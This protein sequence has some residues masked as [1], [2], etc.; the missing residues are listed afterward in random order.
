MVD[1]KGIQNA[2]VLGL[3][4]SGEAAARLLRAKGVAV[5]IFDAAEEASLREDVR[6]DLESLGC[7]VFPGARAVAG[8][9]FDVAVISPGVSDSSPLFTSVV[10]QGI[11]KISEL[12]LGWTYLDV[13]VI[14][15]TGSNGKSTLVKLCAD[16]LR[17]VP[18]QCEAGGNFGTPLCELAMSGTSPD[19]IVAEVSSFQL[20]N[21]VRFQRGSGSY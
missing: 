17:A 10:E 20:E 19:W 3:G 2:C 4:R 16:I 18:L 14:A 12:E 21:C 15:V 7:K 9:A 5:S 8:A 6:E 11:F 13:P 1:L